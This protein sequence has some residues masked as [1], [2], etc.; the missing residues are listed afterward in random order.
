MF[1]PLR[2]A[3]DKRAFVGWQKTMPNPCA[4]GGEDGHFDGLNFSGLACAMG[5][6]RFW[7]RMNSG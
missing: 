2:L 3:Y 7:T 5:A 4:E 1:G 6:A